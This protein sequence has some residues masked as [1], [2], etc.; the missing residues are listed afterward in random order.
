MVNSSAK[1]DTFVEKMCKWF[2]I[3]IHDNVWEKYNIKTEVQDSVKSFTQRS[4]RMRTYFAPADNHPLSL[5]RFTD[6]IKK[7]NK[8]ISFLTLSKS[9]PSICLCNKEISPLLHSNATT[10][11]FFVGGQRLYPKAGRPSHKN[12]EKNPDPLPPCGKVN[13]N[14]P[15]WSLH[16]FL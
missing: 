6:G 16:P 1:W 7:K 13:S 10:N 14:L 12:G 11:H 4:E 5:P 3:I 2:A 15:G 9:A 8:L